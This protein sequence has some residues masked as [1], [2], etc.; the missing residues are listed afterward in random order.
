MSFIGKFAQ[1]DWL[2]GIGHMFGGELGGG[3]LDVARGRQSFGQFAGDA[4]KS[5]AIELPMAVATL[6]VGSA[7]GAAASGLSK[8]ATAAAEGSKVASVASS[9]AKGLTTVATK[10]GTIQGAVGSLKNTVTGGAA[11]LKD[12]AVPDL[13]PKA[14]VAMA[15]VPSAK[16]ELRPKAAVTTA[17]S[18]TGIGAQIKAGAGKAIGQYGVQGA[19]SLISAGMAAKQAGAANEVSK[20]SLLF[21]QQ[22][23]QE[24]KA[25]REKT[26]AE[27]KSSAAKSYES[28]LLFGESLQQSNPSSANLFTNYESAPSD[29]GSNY[30]LLSSSIASMIKNK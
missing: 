8:V 29:T 25:E 28:S 2:G 19:L 30:S 14:T 6:G 13:R 24:Q 9:A 4:G 10:L 1:G 5:L 17:T 27:L 22:T 3:L 23:Y 16:P 26:K 15:P 7:A 18:S 20:Q 12:A 21:Q 11:P